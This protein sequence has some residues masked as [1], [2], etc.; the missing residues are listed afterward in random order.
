[1]T[2]V[3]CPGLDPEMQAC[4]ASIKASFKNINSQTFEGGL[5][6]LGTLAATD[7]LYIICH[8]HA[9]MPLFVTKK[10]RWTAKQ[11]A[12]LVE[13]DGLAKNHREIELLVCH[14]GESV[15]S[16]KAGNARLKIQ[17]A[18]TAAKAAGKPTDKLVASYNKIT[19]PKPA[20]F[21]SNTQLLPMAAQFVQ[22]LKNKRYTNIRII[23]YACP[24]A[25]Y[26]SNGEVM[27][28]LGDKGGQWGQPATRYPQYKKVWL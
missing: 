3:Y 8:G 15:S 11:L 14:A 10:G 16:A 25:Q 7:K 24:V 13:A 18:A 2:T 26:W 1:M 27:L 6:Q 5:K 21:T 12:D 9:Q 19:G 20:E 23:S 28:D 22:E 4:I 17:Q